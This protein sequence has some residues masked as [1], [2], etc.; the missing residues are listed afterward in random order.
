M[1]VTPSV[2]KGA[3]ERRSPIIGC[4]TRDSSVGGTKGK[5]TDAMVK[6]R[7]RYEQN[8]THPVPC[9]WIMVLVLEKE[10]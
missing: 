6:E 4:L 5:K 9:S 1:A 2:V 3:K 7:S 8:K 10:I